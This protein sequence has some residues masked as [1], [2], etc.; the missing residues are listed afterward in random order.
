VDALESR[1][2]L[3]GGKLAEASKNAGKK[4]GDDTVL[5][6]LLFSES[7]TAIEEGLLA[8]S[9]YRDAEAAGKL[10]GERLKLFNAASLAAIC[11]LGKDCGIG[12]Y[13]SQ[14]LCALGDDCSGEFWQKWSDGLDAS[15]VEQAKI[16]RQRIVDAVHGRDLPVLKGIE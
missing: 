4:F 13:H 15:E 2:N 9:K 3:L 16:L 10:N 1:M 7:P 11:D 8:L 6:T 14:L 5:G 12:S